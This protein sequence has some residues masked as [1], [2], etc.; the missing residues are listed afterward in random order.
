MK[1]IACGI[2]VLGFL[3][4]SAKAYTDD[5]TKTLID[6]GEYEGVHDDAETVFEPSEEG[7]DSVKHRRFIHI[8]RNKTR[9]FVFFCSRN[10]PLVAQNSNSSFG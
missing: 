6:T 10:T 8:F 4:F 3:V 1:K 5:D 9:L 7:E 2:A